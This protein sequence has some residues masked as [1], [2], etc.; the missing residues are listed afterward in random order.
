MNRFGSGMR[1]IDHGFVVNLERRSDRLDSFRSRAP[2][3]MGADLERFAAVDGTQLQPEAQLLRL[4]DGNNFHYRRNV[5]GCALSHYS[6]WQRIAHARFPHERV[7]IF[8]DDAWFSKSFL[9]LWN[10]AMAS[11]IPTDFDLI[12]L[13]GL[14]GPATWQ[15]LEEAAA[16]SAGHIVVPRAHY[17]G[18]AVNACFANPL[19]IQFCTYSYIISK[20][21]ADKLCRLVASDGIRFA[22]DWFLIHHWG[23]LQVYVT[24]PLLCW[25]VYE[26]GSDI[27]NNLD[28][29]RG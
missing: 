4:F 19:R 2:G 26:E 7:V 14:I 29:L 6:L 25:S 24:V 16:Q 5:I 18:S 15:S 1:H 9:A 20:R 3:S 13:G 8:E 11:L 23:Q 12:Y 21:G 28:E 17:A 27:F 22:I 10:E